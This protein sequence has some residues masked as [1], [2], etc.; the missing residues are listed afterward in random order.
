MN[1][2]FDFNNLTEALKNGYTDEDIAKAFTTSLNNAKAAEEKRK[3]DEAAKKR[4]AEKM[5]KRD[6]EEKEA[7]NKRAEAAAAALNAFLRG[8]NILA[9]G[10]E[11]FT[12]E[13]LLNFVEQ[14]KNETAHLASILKA[15][16]SVRDNLAAPV[17]KAKNTCAV[18]KNE[19]TTKDDDIFADLFSY[20][21]N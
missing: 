9:A 13:D 20:L 11:C 15:L 5:A 16:N 2:N 8:E 21:F 7:R 17:K 10:D 18:K 1:N 12:S 3:A 6:A 19:A 14:A 4:E